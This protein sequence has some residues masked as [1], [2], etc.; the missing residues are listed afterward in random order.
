MDKWEA[1]TVPFAPF[2]VEFRAGATYDRDGKHYAIALAYVDSRHYQRRMDEAFGPDGWWDQYTI[3]GGESRIVMM[4]GLTAGGVTK[5]DVGEEMLFDRNDNANPNAATTAKAQS[6]K[7]ACGAHGLGRHLYFGEQVW[8]EY[9]QTSRGGFKRWLDDAKMS[10]LAERICIGWNAGPGAD[11]GPSQAISAE[12]ANNSA[13]EPAQGSTGAV[14]WTEP[15]PAGPVDDGLAGGGDGWSVARFEP[16]GAPVI[17]DPDGVIFTTSK[18]VVPAAYWTR[19]K[20]P[21]PPGID[22]KRTSLWDLAQIEG[23]TGL[24]SLAAMAAKTK[25]EE[26]F[27]RVCGILLDTVEQ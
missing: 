4:C 10:Q 9:E 17:V 16:D 1:L 18:M 7:R 20:A 14:E 2:E 6:F 24:P 26:A 27:V 8:C 22:P 23:W 15:V 12:P 21:I 25:D 19:A 11:S 5:W 3:T 13:S